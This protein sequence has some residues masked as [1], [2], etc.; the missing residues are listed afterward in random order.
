MTNRLRG[1]LGGLLLAAGL[2]YGA[3]P[4]AP[5][6]AQQRA[7]AQSEAA[8]AAAAGGARPTMP[9]LQEGTGERQE[10]QVTVAGET[11]DVNK[12]LPGA[13][14]A[15]RDHL[16]EAS[17]DASN[18]NG[19]RQ[20]NDEREVELQDNTQDRFL[21][22]V[23]E[24]QARE[25]ES[26][27]SWVENDPGIREALMTPGQAM[28]G[29]FDGAPIGTCTTTTTRETV[30]NSYTVW[31]EEVCERIVPN[32]NA[33][34][35]T[36]EYDVTTTVPVLDQNER[37]ILQVTQV[38]NGLVCSRTVTVEENRPILSMDR[39]ATLPISS[40]TGGLSCE[41]NRWAETV[42]EPAQRERTQSLP[43]NQEMG[44]LS[45]SR[46]R[47]AETET[48]STGGSRTALLNIN[49]ETGGNSCSRT[50]WPTSSWGTVSQM[51]SATLNVD[52]QRN[53]N[54]GVRYIT[55]TETN[56]SQPGAK[57]GTLSINGETGGLSCSRRLVPTN[58]T[59]TVPGTQTTSL[60]VDSQ[61][62]GELCTRYIWKTNGTGST[63]GSMS[64]SLLI[65]TQQSGLLCSR[66]RWVTSGTTNNGSISVT[67]GDPFG[68][69]PLESQARWLGT[70]PLETYSYNFAPHIPQGTTSISGFSAVANEPF[71][72]C[73]GFALVSPP[74]LANGWVMRYQ[75]WNNCPNNFIMQ[76]AVSVSGT[77]QSSTKQWSI[78][79]SGNCA[80]TGTTNCP[81]TW[82]CGTQAPTT[83]NGISVTAAEVQALAA[84]YSGAAGACTASTLSRTCSGTATR[85]TTVNISG[86]L[87]A[88][89]TAISGFTFNVS[90]PQ[91]GVTVSLVQTPSQANGW[92]AIFRVSRT[93]WAS[94]LAQPQ[95][96]MNWTVG[97]S[98]VALELRESG[99]CAAGG[100]TNCP[101][102]W[103][104]TSSAPTSRSGISITAAEAGGFSPLYPGATNA[105]CTEARKSKAC[106]G[107]ATQTT[108]VSI[109][110]QIPAGT[111][112]ISGFT[113]SVQNPQAGVTVTLTQTP[114]AANS[115]VARFS[116]ARTSWG[117]TAPARPTITMS[118]NAS[119]PTTSV[120]VQESGNCADPGSTFCPTAWSCAVHAPTTV[121]GIPLTTA[122]AASMAPL[123][124]GAANTCAEGRLS[125]VC[126][127]SATQGSTIGIGDVLPAGTESISNFAWT[128]TNP[129]AGVSVTLV[130][131]PTAANGWTATFNVTRTEWNNTPASPQVSLTWDAQVPS[132]ALGVATAG[133]T[134]A[135]GT[136][137]CPAT[138]SC[139]T[140]APTTIS[141]I[142]VTPEMA[143]TQAPIYPGAPTAC[144]RASLDLVCSGTATR[145]TSHSIAARLS[146]GTTSIS[147]FTF[148]VA[149]PQA[150]VAVTLIQ[151]PSAANNWV[152]IFR[153]TR[154]T[155][156][157]VPQPPSV[158]MRWND[159]ITSTVTEVRDTGNCADT[160][161]AS[162]PVSWSCTASAPVTIN[163]VLVTTAMANQHAP[164]YPGAPS[165]CVTGQLN[166]TCS[167]TAT[168]DTSVSILAQLPAGT[169]A[170]ENFRHSV[171]NPQAGVTVAL[172]QT[173]SAANNW[174]AIFRTSRTNW[175]SAPARPEV[176]LEWDVPAQNVVFSVR[177]SGNCS[178][179]GSTVC[180]TSWSCRS[181]APT[182]V[183]GIAVTA[184]MVSGETPLYPGASTACVLGELRR[185][186]TGQATL[187]AS[188][189]VG[190]LI[191]AGATSIRNF[192]FTVNNPQPG[193]TVS[194]ISAP[195]LANGWTATFDIVRSDFSYVPAQPNVT[196]NF[197]VDEVSI[198]LSVRE[199]GNCS[200]PGSQA[201]PTQWACTLSAPATVNGQSITA[202]MVA[203][204]PLLYPGASASCL[205]GQLSRVCSGTVTTTAEVA[206]GD[207]LPAGTTEIFNFAWGQEN[208][209]PGVT[210][211]LV[212]EP[213]NAN[214]WTASFNVTRDYAQGAAVEPDVRLTWNVYGDT[215]Y[216]VG[217][218]DTG[219]C[220][221]G[222]GQGGEMC[223]DEWVC[224]EFDPNPEH[225]R[226]LEDYWRN[227]PPI[228][229]IEPLDP[230]C[231]RGRLVRTC[232]GTGSNITEV[233]IAEH[234]PEGT[235][236]I[237]NY[238][239]TVDNEVVDVGVNSLQDPN[240]ANG[241]VA[242]FET[243]R[244]NWDT[245]PSG[246]PE[247]LLEWQ[248]E[249]DPEH[250]VS[251]IE[252]GDCEDPGSEFCT[253]QWVCLEHA[254]DV[255]G[256]V[257]VPK[258]VVRSLRAPLGAGT[259]VQHSV[260]LAEDVGAALEISDFNVG[261]IAGG[262]VVVT[263]VDMPTAENNWT[264]QIQL[265]KV[266]V[267]EVIFQTVNVNFTWN[268][269]EPAE[270]G[271]DTAPG[272]I[273]GAPPLYEGAPATC[274]RAQ[275]TMNC[276]GINEGEICH[277][278][279]EG[280]WCETVTPGANTCD[281]LEANPSCRL[282][283]NLCSEDGM[284]S[285][286]HCYIQ[287]PVYLCSR[288]VVG[289]DVIVRETTTCDSSQIPICE[290]GI[291]TM[292]DQREI[293]E[294]KVAKSMAML[295]VAET[296][297]SDWKDVPSGGGGGPICGGPR[298]DDGGV[299]IVNSVK[300]AADG[301]PK[302]AAAAT[303]GATIQNEDGYDPW[304]MPPGS[305]PPFASNPEMANAMMAALDPNS[306]RF[307]DGQQMNCMRA[308]GGLLNCC[309]KQTPNEMNSDWWEQMMQKMR[310][311]WTG[312]GACS[313]P[314]AEDPENAE[315]GGWEAL[316]L[317]PS[318]ESLNMGLTSLLE[319]LN[320]GGDTPQ[321]ES[322]DNVRMETVT[323]DFINTAI[324]ETMPSLKWYCDED[325]FE[326]AAKKKLGSCHYL[327]TYCQSRFLGI[328]IDRRQR[329]CCFNSP[330]SR[331]IRENLAE[332][333][334]ATFGTAKR[335][336]CDGITIAQFAELNPSNLDF[337]D[338]EGR[339]IEAGVVGDWLNMDGQ[340][341]IERLTGSLSTI[342][343]DGRM[344]LDERTLARLAGIDGQAVHDGVTG[345]VIGS[346]PTDPR[347][348]TPTAGRISFV[349]GT[350]WVNRG[351]R[352]ELEVSRDGG[353]GAV[354]VRV[355]AVDGSATQ[356]RDFLLSAPITLTWGDGDTYRRIV[357]LPVLRTDPRTT[358]EEQ[359]ELR[360]EATSGGAELGATDRAVILVKPE[361]PCNPNVTGE[362]GCG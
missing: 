291:C 179:P 92:N 255:E 336:T 307:F 250:S 212:V 206:I 344:G 265:E 152:A 351:G 301:A 145:N 187:G 198:V 203:S 360:L 85:D 171:T 308:L 157:V 132:I 232:E 223:R 30:E 17:E 332:Q 60:N 76:A 105:S 178:D 340:D 81:A 316:G 169:T 128:V 22:E 200:D 172:I 73:F 238:R 236:V 181:S 216:E 197:E 28:D 209:T 331:M 43:I 283:R 46:E 246:Q 159:N 89:A 32:P 75:R 48:S 355:V 176:L 253:P 314:G 189:A 151:T 321:C 257:T 270:E 357:T 300:V 156:D 111:T 339:M 4:P 114:S 15:K 199:T 244:E 294:G 186:C 305:T 23:M 123:Y 322:V 315:G 57:N 279:A 306:I 196:V 107:T 214:G 249:G 133:N 304:Q 237:L 275:R 84:L 184:A 242:R 65:D 297:R 166:R 359:F 345:E 53:I 134:A 19:L 68:S 88:G 183:N 119:V 220:E 41:R 343:N 26:H 42:V 131:A 29:V 165:T 109:A 87:P 284:G 18:L 69:Y 110:G 290:G 56:G 136:A 311:G 356:G 125:R 361:P 268:N 174:V 227:L 47:W 170:I 64:A 298:C 173:P 162:C 63:T 226:P 143:A 1:V 155:W 150:G 325:E 37:A 62:S 36:R 97:Y 190:D 229:D 218:E 99:S 233:S 201:C 303:G 104:C 147:N 195:S 83:I 219:D 278:T 276:D 126:S 358:V 228:R 6:T 225:R 287:T 282:D 180:P 67:L 91:S 154:S 44:G 222:A 319:N 51:D 285:D 74:T 33:A 266:D 289:E 98:T 167:G 153:T 191:P 247:V 80:A 66:N 292:E 118:W 90:N 248:I 215:T 281:E 263:V 324:M 211:A 353:L 52:T 175:A 149:N 318:N 256:T 326:L 348:S 313:T 113:F 251:I 94:G 161:T 299:I 45:C 312:V 72:E 337:E 71:P 243:T 142:A 258:R 12:L 101:A 82:A 259:T 5:L 130:S 124:P 27:R 70:E 34:V 221:G 25:V 188:I 185:V 86:Q 112:S 102:T 192:A 328:C 293:D 235:Q 202:A 50:I 122:M 120:T 20:L 330:M 38:S 49:T 10:G 3:E 241:W 158:T 11:L 334:I 129:Q 106:S 272:M 95:I 108:D 309:T 252:E 96:T 121:G 264:V 103:A 127:G 234:L 269:V 7:E 295:A 347:P 117:A 271:G 116:V 346:M 213:S 182:T 8:E 61:T 354:S 335:P 177:E 135:S 254:D 21:D 342:G 262:E 296:M 40:E 329:Y 267:G 115:W 240:L 16:M 288:E 323:D 2:A 245:P 302:A 168:N 260:S 207:L 14:S 193:V 273:T 77:A 310:Q 13:N 317:N 137:N 78:Q 320:G 217:H 205:T 93:N 277:D 349:R 204:E 280:Q 146:P 230:I 210:V 9:S 31:D 231:L 24:R 54:A 141:G 261:V 100:T 286:G 59:S 338:I 362:A 239:W 350:A 163:G 139:T 352:L 144:T 148:T 160:G 164:L 194:L 79:E 55:A 138:W 327:G 224:D 208:S 341:L 274:V 39:I 140:Q 333:G 35:C 58:G